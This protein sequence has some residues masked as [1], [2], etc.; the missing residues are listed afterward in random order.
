V[1]Q[2]IRFPAEL[3]PSVDALLRGKKTFLHTAAAALRCAG[4]NF[5]S[6]FF[7]FY[8]KERSHE[9]VHIYLL[10]RVFSG[11]RVHSTE[12]HS[13]LI[14]CI[15]AFSFQAKFSGR[16]CIFLRT[17]PCISESLFVYLY[18]KDLIFYYK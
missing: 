15:A 6:V 10:L 11:A 17:H 7:L 18:M 9:S 1:T 13:S 4:S 12:M 5:P 14:E 8:F 2:F 16:N 3:A